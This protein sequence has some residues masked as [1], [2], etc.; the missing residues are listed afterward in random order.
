MYIKFSSILPNFSFNRLLISV[1]T[2]EQ[3]NTHMLYAGNGWSEIYSAVVWNSCNL[4]CFMIDYSRCDPSLDFSV[5]YNHNQIHKCNQMFNQKNHINWTQKIYTWCMIDIEVRSTINIHL[6]M[7]YNTAQWCW[8][9]KWAQP[10]NW[11]G[12]LDHMMQEG[13]KSETW[14]SSSEPMFTLHLSH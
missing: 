8:C 1:S 12:M 2:C 11:L 14:G 3:V 13:Q 9:T 5:H 7:Y 6:T 10:L 4:D